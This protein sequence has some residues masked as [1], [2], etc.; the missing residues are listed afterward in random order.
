[1]IA[2]EDGQTR[3]EPDRPAVEARD[4]DSDA[5]PG[6]AVGPSDRFAANL[7]ETSGAM[8][9]YASMNGVFRGADALA[10][11][12]YRDTLIAVCGSPHDPVE[13]MLIEQLALAH[14]NTGRLHFRAANAESLDGARVYGGLAVLLQGELR[15]TALA[16][17]QYRAAAGPKGLVSV[18][19]LADTGGAVKGHAPVTEQ[20]TRRRR[21]G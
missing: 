10:F 20:K 8:F 15:R 19:D 2:G 21:T 6:T 14:L 11:K 3:D 7:A 1:M 4:A 9:M 13:V 16:L 12:K 5:S 18:D 17:K